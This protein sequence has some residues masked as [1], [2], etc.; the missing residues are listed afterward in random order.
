MRAK[1][2]A[3]HLNHKLLLPFL[4]RLKRLGVVNIEYEAA[5][6][7]A[8]IEGRAEALEALLSSGIPYL[9]CCQLAIDGCLL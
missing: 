1:E 3:A 5:A 8:A 4:K 6:I 2:A 7:C 9:Q